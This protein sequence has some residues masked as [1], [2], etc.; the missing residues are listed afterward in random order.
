MNHVIDHHNF[1]EKRKEKFNANYENILCQMEDIEN[2]IYLLEIELENED[3]TNYD[4]KLKKLNCLEDEYKSLK[5]RL[6]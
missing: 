1:M 5:S 3:A 4:Q 2:K 6:E